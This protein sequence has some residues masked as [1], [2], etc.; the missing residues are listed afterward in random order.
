MYSITLSKIEGK[1]L[2]EITFKDAIPP[3]EM[4]KWLAEVK[5][6]MPRLKSPFYIKVDMVDMAVLTEESQKILTEGQKHCLQRGMQRSIVI[7]KKAIT[8]MQLARIAKESGIYQ[9]E[10]YVSTELPGYQ[11][12]ASQW[13]LYGTGL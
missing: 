8:S 13:L 11:N 7:V 4:Q 9:T 5:Q 1:D 2:V 6:T 12:K 10:R 3:V